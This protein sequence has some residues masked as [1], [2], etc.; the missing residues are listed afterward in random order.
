MCGPLT[1]ITLPTS[2]VNDST[3]G[4]FI[5]FA[6]NTVGETALFR[7]FAMNN[8]LIGYV[9]QASKGGDGEDGGSGGMLLVPLMNRQFKVQACVD[10]DASSTRNLHYSV[11][12]SF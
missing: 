5:S 10:E 9:G 1:V 8:F 12:G 7:V 3:R 11:L 4:A 6:N 2:D